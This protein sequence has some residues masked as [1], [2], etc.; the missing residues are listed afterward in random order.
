MAEYYTKMVM[1]PLSDA[2][3]RNLGRPMEVHLAAK[4]HMF[5][6]LSLRHQADGFI[7]EDEC[8]KQIACLQVSM[9]DQ[10]PSRS[11]RGNT[12]GK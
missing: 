3:R 1:A 2:L 7:A 9:L 6:A 12:G 8:G 11:A 5:E 4:G 10:H